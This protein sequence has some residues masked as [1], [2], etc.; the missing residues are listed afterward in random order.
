MRSENTPDTKYI[1]PGETIK[2]S[3][4]FGGASRGRAW[5]KCFRGKCRPTGDF[6]WVDKTGGTL[7]LTEPGY[8]IVG[9]HDGFRRKA[10]AE[11]VL[12]AAPAPEPEPAPEPDYVI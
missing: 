6:E 4:R 2:L 9:S 3:T 1:R 12:L 7:Y 5:G 8:Y 11:F 10:R